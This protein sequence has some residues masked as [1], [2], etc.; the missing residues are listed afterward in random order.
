MSF[1]LKKK[2]KIRGIKKNTS[3]NSEDPRKRRQKI[4]E[5]KL[6]LSK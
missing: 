2:K 3:R 5:T 1:N 6:Y 4:R